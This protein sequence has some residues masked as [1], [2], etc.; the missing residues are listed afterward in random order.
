[1][2][3]PESA[4]PGYQGCRERLGSQFQFALTIGQLR[5]RQTH[6]LLTQD[7]AGLFRTRCLAFDLKRDHARRA[8][9]LEQPV[10]R[11]KNLEREKS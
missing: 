3:T 9:R 5:A 11:K 4:P 10:E 1:M 8:L 6:V 7:R 2:C